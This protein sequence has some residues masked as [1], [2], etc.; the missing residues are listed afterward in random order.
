MGVVPGLAGYAR[1][2]TGR[3]AAPLYLGAALMAL[4]CLSLLQF[5][6]VRRRGEGAV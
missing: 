4:A 1:D 3:A 6:L 2:A 5:R